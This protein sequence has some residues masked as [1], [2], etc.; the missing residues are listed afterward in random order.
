MNINKF[1]T[2]LGFEKTLLPMR[3]A[4]ATDT[5][6]KRYRYSISDYNKKETKEIMTEAE[7]IVYSIQ[8]GW[9]LKENTDKP[10]R[11]CKG[12]HC[13]DESACPKGKI[14]YYVWGKKYGVEITKTG[15]DFAL[16]LISED[17]LTFD[18]IQERIETE[19]AAKEQSE[20]DAAKAEQE[21]KAIAEAEEK[22]ENE[23]KEWLYETTKNY[24]SIIVDPYVKGITEGEK[25]LIMRDIYLDIIGEYHE[26]AK[27]LLVLIDNIGNPRCRRDLISRLHANNIA[28]IK[29]FEQITGIK[30]AKTQKERSMQLETITKSDYTTT[31][32]QYI[33]RKP[34][35]QAEYNDI[36][37][38]KQPS[39]DGNNIEFIESCGRL[40]KYNGYDFFITY[41]EK[42]KTAIYKITEGKTG[43]LVVRGSTL[44]EA[45]DT[46]R[47]ITN[48][49]R[50][51]KPL[52]TSFAKIIE[53]NIKNHGISPLY[54][55][56]VI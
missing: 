40:W 7:F 26:R 29:T 38:I 56:M 36:F 19:K 30:L 37:Y 34:N 23:Y 2:L 39:G 46:A 28:S 8:Q 22:A 9:G 49:M 12:L 41:A 27:T 33:P 43:V 48:D 24:G 13:I 11:K 44:K 31:P 53:Q 10:C 55:E 15:Y 18:S 47:E 1:D 16:W 42:N 20:R 45:K 51:G 35:E 54:K 52:G 14:K 4:R 32:K 21:Q 5:L 25:V 6:G 50:G 17:L 3:A